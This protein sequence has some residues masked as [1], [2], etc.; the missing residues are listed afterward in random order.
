M[1]FF[2]FSWNLQQAFKTRL[3][4]SDAWK[5]LMVAGYRVYQ[6]R[7]GKRLFWWQFMEKE[8][9]PPMFGMVID[10]ATNLTK[11]KNAFVYLCG[12]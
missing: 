4:P 1:P 6:G 10:W 7:M 3:F 5:V 11:S 8:G 9:I 12:L 2:F